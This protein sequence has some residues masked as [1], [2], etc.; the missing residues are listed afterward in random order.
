MLSA[1]PGF[2]QNLLAECV[3]GGD[4]D[5]VSSG[6]HV[7][8]VTEILEG[9]GLSRLDVQSHAECSDV[10][11]ETQHLQW[12]N[13]VWNGDTVLHTAA[14][15]GCS[16]LI[17]VLMRYGADPVVKNH[18]G[19]TPYLVAKNKEV[20]D[21]FR[22]FMAE[23]PAAYGYERAYIPSPLTQ[24]MEMER[25]RKEA[26]KRKEKKKAKKQREKVTRSLKLKG[27]SSELKGCSSKFGV[28]KE[29]K[30]E[31]EVA[32]CET[33]QQEAVASLSQQE[34]LAM[35]AERRMASQLPSSHSLLGK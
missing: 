22:R 17:P 7:T 34:K 19:H 8:A 10:S 23:F 26:E 16:S 13:S 9:V 2:V 1:V 28:L 33:V 27:H 3:D 15:C 25:S 18:A 31:R 4:D 11:G 20:R 12:L 14:A 35:A 30:A 32:A 24:E 21:S 6:A 29:R 5:D